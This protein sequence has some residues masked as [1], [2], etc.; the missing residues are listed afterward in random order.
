MI[1]I[2]YCQFYKLKV[3]SYWNLNSFRTEL[4]GLKTSLKVLSYW[5]LNSGV[6]ESLENI[7]GLKVLSYW[8]LNY[9]SFFI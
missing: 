3:L 4:D 6:N 8:N 1:Y 2:K 5:N 7:I 9:H